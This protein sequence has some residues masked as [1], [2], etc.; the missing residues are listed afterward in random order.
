M[1]KF[2]SENTVTPTILLIRRIYTIL[3]N[4]DLA[5]FIFSTLAL[6]MRL[7]F[8]FVLVLLQAIRYSVKLCRFGLNFVISNSK[9]MIV[10]LLDFYLNHFSDFNTNKTQSFKKSFSESNLAYLS[11]QD[12]NKNKNKGVNTIKN[13]KSVN[14]FHQSNQEKTTKEQ[15]KTTQFTRLVSKMSVSLKKKTRSP[16]GKVEDLVLS[17]GYPLVEYTVETQD[18]FYLKLFRIPY[19]KKENENQKIQK[20]NQNRPVIFFQHGIMSSASFFLIGD[21][22]AY[23]LSDMGY[24]CWFGNTRGNEYSDKHRS[25]SRNDPEYW[26]HTFDD[27]VE[28]DLPAMVNFVL[29]KTKQETFTYIAFSQGTAQGFAAFSVFPELCKKCNLFVAFAPT[30][31]IRFIDT[32]L[33]DLLTSLPIR[34]FQMLIGK[35]A[36]FRKLLPIAQ[37]IV[38]LKGFRYVIEFCMTFLFGWH[39]RN[40]NKEWMPE[41]SQTLYSTMSS[42]IILHWMQQL[43]KQTFDRYDFEDEK[44]NLVKYGQ[45][46]PPEYDL[47]KINCPMALYS[48]G[49]D[50]LSNIEVVAKKKLNPEYVIEDRRT[51]DFEHLDSV[52]GINL[53]KHI[54]PGVFKFMDK[55]NPI[56][57]TTKKIDKEKKVNC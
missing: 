36:V 56:N 52:W 54:F 46:T 23:Q 31:H 26:D 51:P 2:P 57:N 34:Y 13:S 47:S 6:V 21:T 20:I 41:Y 9:K 3:L 40:L 5:F 18:G 4:S 22:I 17:R 15:K 27:L 33:L 29:E 14:D 30:A 53:D 24:D 1:I 19:G 50:S 7:L 16:S 35:D 10:N 43:R 48:G 37:E 55:Y 28:Q 11:K 32:I 42:K 44:K 49:A 38:G 39:N 8:S 45:K 25:L 12:K